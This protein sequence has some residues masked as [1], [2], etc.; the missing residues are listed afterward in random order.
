MA[1]HDK[2][3]RRAAWDVYQA[4]E[5]AKHDADIFQMIVDFGKER[6]DA[7]V[8]KAEEEAIE[9]AELD[10]ESEVF[11]AACEELYEDEYDM[12]AFEQGYDEPV[13][14]GAGVQEDTFTMDEVEEMMGVSDSMLGVH[15][16]VMEEEPNDYGRGFADGFTVAEES[17]KV[18]AAYAEARYRA[19]YQDGIELAEE[20]YRDGYRAGQEADMQDTYDQ[21]YGEGFADGMATVIS[22]V[23]TEVTGIEDT[24]KAY[25]EGFDKGYAEGFFDGHNEYNDRNAV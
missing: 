13:I 21:G 1:N 17:Y 20:R 10:A 8:Q 18:D 5:C 25:D 19:G 22:D 4:I 16:C 7:G 14:N 9:Q 23:P 11:K 3:N 2:R 6:F 24:Q 15:E 12:T